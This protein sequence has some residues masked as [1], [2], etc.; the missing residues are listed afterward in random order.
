MEL[1]GWRHLR[2]CGL[3][4]R[5][6]ARANGPGIG[7]FHQAT[8]LIGSRSRPGK[9]PVDAITLTFCFPRHRHSSQRTYAHVLRAGIEPSSKHILR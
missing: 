6:I 2:E 9:E 3:E 8:P 7:Q 4:G 1:L 5:P